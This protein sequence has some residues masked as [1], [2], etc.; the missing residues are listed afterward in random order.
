MT[1]SKKNYKYLR[2]LLFAIYIVN[3]LLVIPRI[4]VNSDEGD[5]FGY[6]IRLVKGNPEK[7]KP[8]DDASTMPV[9]ALNVIPR[10]AEQILQP[11]LE[12]NDWGNSDI[13]HGRYITL[14]ICL[15]TGIFIYAWSKEMYGEKAGLLSL[16]L[17]AFCPNII[18]QATLFTTDAFAALFTVS[19]LYYYWKFLRT[20]LWKHVI[21][22]GISLGAAQLTKQSLTHLFIILLLFSFF[23][24]WQRK[25]LLSHALKNLLRT[26]VAGLLVVLIINIGFLFSETGKTFGSYQFTSKFFNR[27]QS[28]FSF[29]NNVPMPLPSPYVKGLDLTKRMDEMGPG[30]IE[31]SGNA[32]LLGKSKKGSGFWYYY[33]VILFFKTPLT[34]LFAVLLLLAVYFIRPLKKS[35]WENELV[36]L[37]PVIWFLIFF[38]FFVNTQSGMRHILI[39]YPLLYILLGRIAII[40]WNKK[41][42]GW[43]AGVFVVCSVATFYS[44]FP[45]FISYTNELLWNKKN[46]YRIMADSNIDFGQGGYWLTRYLKENPN[47]KMPEVKPAA[48]TFIIGV[49]EFLDLNDKHQCE[50]LTKNFKP[51]NHLRHCFLIFEVSE[52]ELKQKGLW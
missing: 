32:Y 26:V 12:K 8:F 48:G 24:L 6:A 19:T 3:G 10:V 22:L 23:V 15:L 1:V 43:Y 49:N 36:L 41:F 18:A 27:V 21:L 20:G 29:L 47:V 40:E 38:S 30:H 16:F 42:I 31:V 14:F 11:G 44:F 5:H 35:F 2:I 7:V 28:S 46:V 34:I 13:I 17:F 37:F 9:S 52:T 51:V 50:W 33:F 4:S 39:I 25:T 45:N